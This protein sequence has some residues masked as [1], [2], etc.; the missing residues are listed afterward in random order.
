MRQLYLIGAF[1]IAGLLFFITKDN[2]G[3]EDSRSLLTR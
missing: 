2:L 1:V 3:G